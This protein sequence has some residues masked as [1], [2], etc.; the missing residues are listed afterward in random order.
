[1]DEKMSCESFKFTWKKEKGKEED[2]EWELEL[3]EEK[4]EK[5]REGSHLCWSYKSF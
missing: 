3:D 4:T 1:M 2:R 5:T